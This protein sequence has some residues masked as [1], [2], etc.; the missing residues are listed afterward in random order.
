MLICPW[1]EGGKNLGTFINSLKN[2]FKLYIT[3]FYVVIAA[4]NQ[5]IFKIGG[6]I[7]DSG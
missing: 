2:S 4:I 6:K 7:A 3:S 5:S 1:L